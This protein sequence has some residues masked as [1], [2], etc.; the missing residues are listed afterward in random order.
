[1]LGGLCLFLPDT[2]PGGPAGWSKV[3]TQQAH[4]PQQAH[5]LGGRRKPSGSRPRLVPGLCE[6]RGRPRGCGKVDWPSPFGIDY[7]VTGLVHRTP[8]GGWRDPLHRFSCLLL[9][10]HQLGP[11][12]TLMQPQR[13]PGLHVTGVAM[14][15]DALDHPP[16]PSSTL[17]SNM[18]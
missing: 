2:G 9:C 7:T 5:G 16:C 4:N 14:V 18:K 17:L 11:S 8:G 13:F 10:G 1:M 3:E 12:Q 15:G 6:G